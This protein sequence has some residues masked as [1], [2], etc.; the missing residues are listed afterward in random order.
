[1][2]HDS[3]N[4]SP[5][6][7]RHGRLPDERL[8]PILERVRLTDQDVDTQEDPEPEKVTTYPPEEV[9]EPSA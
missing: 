2:S 7:D 1:M 8:P 3:D 4:G 5:D 6:H 9:D